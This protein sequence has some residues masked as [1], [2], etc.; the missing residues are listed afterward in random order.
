M[1]KND[2]R[3]RK[4]K[5]DLPIWHHVLGLKKWQNE[6]AVTYNINATPNYFVLDKNKKIIGKPVLLKDLKSFLEQL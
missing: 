1:E 5:S 6:T 3:W 4:M 2:A